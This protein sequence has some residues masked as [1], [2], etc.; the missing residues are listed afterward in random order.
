MTR[1]S[2]GLAFA[3]LAL[4]ATQAC[5]RSDDK[6]FNAGARSA[7]KPEAK[8]EAKLEIEPGID[9]GIKPE[10]RLPEVVR[11]ERSVPRCPK[12]ELAGL[13]ILPDVVAEHRRFQLPVI[14]YPQ[15]PIPKNWGFGLS[16]RVDEAGRV[17]CYGANKNAEFV[18]ERLA[19]LKTLGD[20][21]YTPFTR[22]NRQVTALVHE[23][24]YEE[25]S[26]ATHRPLP[27]VPLEQVRIVLERGSTPSES[28]PSYR[29][30][31]RGDGSVF[32]LGK[33][34][35]MLYG[36]HRYRVPPR[37]V[38]WLVDSLRNKD[39]WSLKPV[40]EADIRHFQSHRLSITLGPHTQTLKNYVGHLVG[41]PRAVYEFEDEVARIAR[42]AMW[43]DLEPRA[44]ELLKA[45]GFVF[46]SPAGAELLARAV[47]GGKHEDA[48]LALIELGAPIELDDS[49]KTR[50]LN[51]SRPLLEVALSRH[52]ERVAQVLIDRG[53]LETDGRRD[54]EKIDAAFRAAVAGGRLN[55]VELVWNT[56]GP[57]D[58][59]SLT[60]TDTIKMWNGPPISKRSPLTLT[61]RGGFRDEEWDGAGVAQW[62]AARGCDLRARSAQGDTL[63]HIAATSGDA[64][65]MRYL[66]A[67]GVNPSIRTKSGGLA[68]TRTRDEEVALMLL[69][70]G[71][72][73][74]A[75]PHGPGTPNGFV[76]VR[77]IAERDHMPRV[78][79]WL[80]AHPQGSN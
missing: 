66:L 52:L 40:Y 23:T 7:A 73:L 26:P 79:E 36:E 19:I 58:R 6:T 21:Q 14:R 18:G 80:E 37:E 63:L 39:I 72:D 20:W 50:N 67:Q 65:L 3:L 77:I 60:Y 41:M 22:D 11:H 76:S 2:I 8:L 17:V 13:P 38:A 61:L 9:L 32:Y 55:L 5:S 74:S 4:L 69:K 42:I 24:V 30:E 68:V 64:R 31:I 46:S 56:A 33:E 53:A 12:A 28:E 57:K 78:L 62:L 25:E 10:S 49:T 35:M 43:S 34:R 44:L 16:L 27:E 48:M 70:A 45:E 59:P 51:F 71:T 29:V 15:N 75:T 47:A 1:H 54:R